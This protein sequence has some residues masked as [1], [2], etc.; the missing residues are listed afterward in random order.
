VTERERTKGVV[1]MMPYGSYQL[2]QLER[3]K[4]EAERR[5]ADAELG[6]LAAELSR[7]F[8]NVTGPLRGLRRHRLLRP[9]SSLPTAQIAAAQTEITCLQSGN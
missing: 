7:F 9:A 1:K 4:T 5:R 2:W 6:M 3:S 8:H